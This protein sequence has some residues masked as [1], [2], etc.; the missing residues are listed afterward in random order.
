MV[1]RVGSGLLAGM[2][3][4]TK[5]AVRKPYKIHVHAV[6]CTNTSSEFL[7]VPGDKFPGDDAIFHFPPFFFSLD[8]IFSD[9]L[10]YKVRRENLQF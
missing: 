6:P 7:A 3:P 4:K 2:T 1:R 8:F 9:F 10:G 5:L